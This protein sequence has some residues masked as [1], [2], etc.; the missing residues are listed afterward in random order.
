M[1]DDT[2][3]DGS[4]EPTDFNDSKIEWPKLHD[5]DRPQVMNDVR[6]SNFPSGS[7]FQMADHYSQGC[8][9]I[10]AG[11]AAK[12]WSKLGK[13]GPIPSVFQGRIGGCKG[14]WATSTSTSTIDQKHQE[15]WIEIV[16]SQRKFEPHAEDED[17]SLYD[18]ERL[19][20][21]VVNHSRPPSRDKLHVDFLPILESRGVSFECLASIVKAALEHEK[22]QLFEALDNP[23]GL[24]RWI[25]EH[26]QLGDVAKRR[27]DYLWFAAMPLYL[28]DRINYLLEVGAITNQRSELI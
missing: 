22:C 20:F 24:R 25:H 17:D 1:V 7:R 27:G 15:L 13:S 11:A 28:G 9:K 23:V 18:P 5:A 21:E 19:T 12:I 16:P 10:S 6:V 3:A 26:F 4:P 8:S 2:L 14:L